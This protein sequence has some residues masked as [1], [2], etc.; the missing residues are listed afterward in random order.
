MNVGELKQRIA[1][2]PDDYNVNLAKGMAVYL[3]DLAQEDRE[4]EHEGLSEDD[5]VYELIYETTLAGLVINHDDK[6]IRFALI[7]R[8]KD[9]QDLKK[10][11]EPIPFPEEVDG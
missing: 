5:V 10:F 9:M 6:E 2:L 3:R 7:S 1:D 11:G 4:D 8:D